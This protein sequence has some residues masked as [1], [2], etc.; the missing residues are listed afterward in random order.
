[1]EGGPALRGTVLAFQSG[2]SLR[3][4]A[5]CPSAAAGSDVPDVDDELMT[6]GAGPLALELAA[7]AEADT[8]GAGL[9]VADE[10]SANAT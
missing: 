10:A 1:M 4:A 2:Y 7:G 8:A 5:A 9:A 3:L 6:T